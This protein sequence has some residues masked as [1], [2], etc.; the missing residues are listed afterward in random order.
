MRSYYN[1]YCTH[2]RSL[3][4]F[5]L[6]FVQKTTPLARICYGRDELGVSDDESGGDDDSSD[7][8]GINYITENERKSFTNKNSELNN[9]N[10][11]TKL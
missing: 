1:I 5:V 9:S 8:G 7:Y 4:I 11:Q 3:D 10:F 2:Y 6:D